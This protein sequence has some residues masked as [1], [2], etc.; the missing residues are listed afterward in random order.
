MGKYRIVID[1]QGFHHNAADNDNQRFD[2]D[3]A[4][5]EF[6]GRLREL[7]QAIESAS[8]Q[9]GFD[10]FTVRATVNDDLLAASHANDDVLSDAIVEKT[11]EELSLG[12]AVDPN[13]GQAG[14]ENLGAAVG[15]G[16]APDVVLDADAGAKTDE[17]A[18]ESQQH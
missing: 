12:G 18:D 3:K 5:L 4:A 10:S 9:T 16:G 7:G 11:Q 6:V 17:R 8:F 1:G 15:S 13:L 2:A 14:D